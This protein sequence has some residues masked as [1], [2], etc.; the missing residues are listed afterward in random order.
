M[1]FASIN[2]NELYRQAIHFRLSAC[3]IIIPHPSFLS[4]SSS[5]FY[6]IYKFLSFQSCIFHKFTEGSPLKA[7]PLGELAGAS[8]TERARLLTENHRHS[9][10]IA[11]TKSLPIAA[12][13]LFPAGLALSVIASQCHLSQRERPWQAGQ[14]YAGRL[15][16]DRTQKGG[17]CLRGQRLLDNAPCQAVASPDSGALLLPRYCASLVQTKAGRHANGSP[18]GGAGEEQGDETERARLWQ[19]ARRKKTPFRR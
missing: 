11:L 5:H 9:D 3:V 8:P 7:P 12:Q 19:A 6:H 18:S 4:I 13:R 1:I 16:L 17:P 15:R 2:K 14:V 10:S